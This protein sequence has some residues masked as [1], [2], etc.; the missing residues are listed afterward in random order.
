MPT[1]EKLFQSTVIS[2]KKLNEKFRL[3]RLKVTTHGFIFKTGQFIVLKV[4]ESVFRSY[5]IASLPSELPYW[6]ILVDITPGGPGTT[7]LR[8]LKKGDIIR[9]SSPKGQFLLS[10]KMGNYIFGATG[11]G[12]APF[13]PMIKELSTKNKNIFLFWGLRYQQ[14]ITLTNLLKSYQKLNPHFNYKIVLSQPD[15]G[16]TG[17]KGH[18]TPWLLKKALPLRDQG[19]NIYLSGSRQFIQETSDQLKRKRI[20]SKKIYFEACY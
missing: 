16:W 4:T 6:N 13:L 10:Q 15:A 18:I 17:K 14:D 9:T 20:P 7:Y 2:N 19:L 11:C 1:M 5:S 12:L 8:S 3:I